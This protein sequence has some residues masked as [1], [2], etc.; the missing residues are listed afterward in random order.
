MRGSVIVLVQH[1]DLIL[2]SN[3]ENNN[4]EYAGECI[5]Y[6]DEQACVTCSKLSFRQ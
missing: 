1:L 3:T 5:D 4:R 2:I 6:S